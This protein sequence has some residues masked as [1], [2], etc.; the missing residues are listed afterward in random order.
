[1]LISSLDNSEKKKNLEETELYSIAKAPYVEL[2]DDYNIDFIL[3]HLL[4]KKEL[5]LSFPPL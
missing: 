2:D 4:Q 1:M 5:F 3:F